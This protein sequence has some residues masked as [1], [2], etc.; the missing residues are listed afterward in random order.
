MPK[1][2]PAKPASGGK[3]GRAHSGQ[4]V[5]RL[6]PIRRSLRNPRSLYRRHPRPHYTPLPKVS[7]IIRETLGLLHEGWRPLL[8]ITAMYSLLSLFFVR[9]MSLGNDNLELVRS[10]HQP[11]GIWGKAV[12]LASGLSASIADSA[13]SN[14]APTTSMYQIIVFVVCSLAIIYALR[15]LRNAQQPS[16]KQC[17]YYGMNQLIPFLLV[18]AVVAVQLLP[19]AA[20]GYLYNILILQ[21][22]AYKWYEVAIA[23]S[24]ILLLVW[25]SLRMLTSG[26]FALYIATLPD[27]TPLRALRSAKKLIWKRRLQLWRKILPFSIICGLGLACCM[28]PVLL[29]APGIAAFVVFVYTCLI[30]TLLHAYIYTLYRTML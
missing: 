26:I 2:S 27:M 5:R 12:S 29:W 9:G 10:V 1:K 7:G 15:Q 13:L 19:L 23:W 28:V 30:F 22:I 25:W 21:G 16:T 18:L 14:A 8:G 6:A 24:L 20:S 11:D 17:F 4:S 3:T